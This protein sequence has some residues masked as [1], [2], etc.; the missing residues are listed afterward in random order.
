MLKTESYPL[1]RRLYL[2]SLGQPKHAMAKDFLEFALSREAQP[3][4]REAGFVDQ[5]ADLQS[6]TDQKLWQDSLMTHP[7]GFLP[8]GKWIPTAAKA[9]FIRKLST[10]RRTS[11][12]LR[13][14]RGS[15]TLDARARQDV[16][17]FASFLATPGAQAMRFWLAGFANSEG[18]WLANEKLSAQRAAT[19]ASALR[20]A[21]ATAPTIE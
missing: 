7:T 8:P 13:F 1:A 5:T 18:T 10:S 6:E 2:Y 4:V 16:Q 21:G 11:L 12:V 20:T 17:S 9:N 14:E 19:V 15:A 3:T